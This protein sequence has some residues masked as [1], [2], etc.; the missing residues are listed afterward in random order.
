MVPILNTLH[1]VNYSQRYWRIIIGPWLNDFIRLI[2]DYYTT[3]QNISKSKTITNTYMA[4]INPAD[5]VPQNFASFQEAYSKAFYNHFLFNEE[6]NGNED[7]ER[8]YISRKKAT[9]RKISN[10]DEL[11]AILTKHNF[12]IYNQ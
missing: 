4:E 7:G 11:E 2:F 9:R 12:K 10:E 8:V 3:I 1:N 5:Q 6:N